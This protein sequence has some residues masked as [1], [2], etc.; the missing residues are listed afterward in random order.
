MTAHSAACDAGGGGTMNET[1]V[2]LSKPP[3]PA[4]ITTEICIVGSGAAGGTAAWE[5]ARA[6]HEVVVVEEGGDF[7]GFD[8]TGRDA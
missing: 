8:L 1:I 5:L 7:T 6:G 4:E 3:R 2:D